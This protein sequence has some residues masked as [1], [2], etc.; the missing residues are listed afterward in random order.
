MTR[1][2]ISARVVLALT[3]LLLAANRLD[4]LAAGLAGTYFTSA[5]D[6]PDR[7]APVASGDADVPSTAAIERAW[8]GTPP[9]VFSA[10]WSGSLFVAHAGTY[11]LATTSD[12]GSWVYVDGEPVVDNGGRHRALTASG[13]INLPR[14][15]HTILVKYFQDG[16]AFQLELLAAAGDARLA[17]MPSWMLAPRQVSYRRFLVSVVLRRSAQ[18][19][20]PVAAAAFFLVLALAG[21]SCLPAFLRWIAR[22]RLRAAFA[23]VALLSLALNASGIWWG[24]P[25]YSWA[26]DE[27]TPPAVYNAIGSWFSQGWYARW[28]PLHFYVLSAAYVPVLVGAWAAGVVWGAAGKY[29]ALVFTSRL[30]SLAAALATIAVVYRCGAR[31][32][33]RRAG[34]FAAL[35]LALLVPFVYYAKTANVDA[36]LTFWI[37]LSL[38]FLLRVLQQPALRNYVGFGACAALAVCTKDQAY[39]VYIA[40]PFVIVYAGWRRNL[41]AG[42]PRPLVRAAADRRLAAA[43]AAAAGVF[44]LCHNLLFNVE[45]FVRHVK[46]ITGAGSE[47]YRLFEPT[48]SGR[49]ALAAATLRLDRISWGWPLCVL[50]AI[51]FAIA[52]RDR[53]TRPVAA[54]L[55]AIAATYYV[56]FINV[57]LYN[58]DRFLLPVCLVQA[59]FIGVACDRLLSPARARVWAAAAVA[60]AFGYSLLYAAT[61]DVVMA[62]DSRYTAERW[63][64]A[65][66]GSGEVVATMFPLQYLPRLDGLPWIEVRS[67][68]DLKE[69]K[70]AFYVL[71]ADYARALAPDSEPGELV[72]GLQRDAL[73]YTL[74]LRYRGPAPWAWLPWGHPDLV[75]PRL[76]LPVFTFFRNI[77]PTIEVYRRKAAASP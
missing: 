39:A 15:V 45:G 49:I 68:A 75:G 58:Y 8:P 30:V 74:A 67:V 70:P 33:S 51:G 62:R 46:Y 10:V 63:L 50:S 73:G 2:A 9:A 35:A 65:H 4:P 3:V 57:I 72:A 6:E 5:R 66:V 16:G 28:P 43:G 37:A 13:R 64:H 60:A 27:L 21:R 23:S 59:L 52:L 7:Q 61:V 11:R 14:G 22:D 12:D 38:L 69:A 44:A 53:R 48:W 56:G 71:N 41:A 76:D 29:T 18:L 47:G 36:P 24:L 31:A 1:V 25:G 32:F 20:W 34:A 42:V 77:N 17:P 55:A 26:G 54:A 40:A 19:A